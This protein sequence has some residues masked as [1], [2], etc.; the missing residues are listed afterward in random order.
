MIDITPGEGRN[1]LF[2][3][4]RQ[5]PDDFAGFHAIMPAGDWVRIEV[6]CSG[7]VGTGDIMQGLAAGYNYVAILSCGVD[8]CI[9][10]FGCREAKNAMQLAKD[11]AAVAGIDPSCLIFIEADDPEIDLARR[12]GQK[13]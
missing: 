6:P 4:T 12:A 1:L 5:N 8:S 11:T 10:E 7:R 9:H 2:F 3:C 13:S